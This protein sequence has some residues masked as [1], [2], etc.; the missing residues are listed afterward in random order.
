MRA[1]DF[2]KTIEEF[3]YETF[4]EEVKDLNETLEGSGFRTTPLLSYPS[5]MLLE[6][7]I[8]QGYH[9]HKFQV[10]VGTSLHPFFTKYAF[11]CADKEC[12]SDDCTVARPFAKIA[13]ERADHAMKTA[14]NPGMYS[15]NRPYY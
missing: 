5:R 6:E 3:E 2:R 10:P 7:G 11:I 12:N 9:F 4:E 1:S 14:F 15:L 13:C 8:R